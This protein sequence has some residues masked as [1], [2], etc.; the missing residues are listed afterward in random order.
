MAFF[1][2]SPAGRLEALFRPSPAAAPAWAAVVCHPHPLYGGT[3]HNKVVF[4]VDKVL[5]GAGLPV[6][7]F[8]FRGVGMSSGR[9]GDGE[10]ETE[11]VIAALDY[12]A[13]RFPQAR[14]LV[15]GFSFGSW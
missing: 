8:N 5:S 6:L 3:M 14:L 4:H 15:A 12:M 11:D 7:R 1:I 9:Y 13:A 10:G 2:P